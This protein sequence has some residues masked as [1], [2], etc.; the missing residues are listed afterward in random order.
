VWKAY[1]PT[2]DQTLIF[3]TGNGT[4]TVVPEPS[5]IVMLAMAGGVAGVFGMRRRKNQKSAA[6]T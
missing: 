3:A 2:T 1:S 4:L 6:T 5:S